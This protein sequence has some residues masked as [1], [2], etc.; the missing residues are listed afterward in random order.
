MQL[1]QIICLEVASE[2]PPS[3][4]LKGQVSSVTLQDPNFLWKP[5]FLPVFPDD[6]LENPLLP[7][8]RSDYRMLVCFLNWNKFI[9]EPEKFV[10]LWLWKVSV[11]AGILNFK[12]I[13][14]RSISSN[15][16]W[17]GAETRVAD[18]NSHRMTTVFLQKLN[19]DVFTVKPSF[20]PTAQCY[21]VDYS[22][23]LSSRCNGPLFLR[24]GHKRLSP[25]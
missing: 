13:D 18:G 5:A 16:V 14:F 12:G 8:V 15:Y 25:Y 10:N 7:Q 4:R 21:L 1:A 19:Q 6:L 23:H 9:E 20:S 22:A 24:R 11:V 3:K 2:I 17:Q